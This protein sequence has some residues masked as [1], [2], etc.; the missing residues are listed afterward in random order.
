[1]MMKMI[2]LEVKNLAVYIICFFACSKNYVSVY[3]VEYLHHELRVSVV[4]LC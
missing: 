1:M 3:V 2:F 4:K